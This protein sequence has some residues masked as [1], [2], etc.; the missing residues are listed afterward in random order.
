MTPAG[1]PGRPFAK[2]LCHLDKDI[3]WISTSYPYFFKMDV[4]VGEIGIPAH[5]PGGPVA[6]PK[7][8]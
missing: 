8:Y 3:T 1:C 5:P 2:N 4:V 6:I 7:S